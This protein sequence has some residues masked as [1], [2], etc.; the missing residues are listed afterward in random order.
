MTK[1]IYN[2]SGAEWIA[3]SSTGGGGEGGGGSGGESNVF[4]IVFSL[5]DSET[6][7]DPYAEPYTATCDMLL[8]DI[9][10]AKAEGKV[11]LPVCDVETSLIS[12]RM[13]SVF[14]QM[15]VGDDI[16]DFTCTFN[17][18]AAAGIL[19]VTTISFSNEYGITADMTFFELS[20]L[21]GGS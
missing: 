2:Q 15:V 6:Q 21:T 11:L 3:V 1:F 12:G 18:S 13:Y 19:V 7:E 17:Y 8:D 20:P 9:I 10:A 16:I 5:T 4:P 14:N